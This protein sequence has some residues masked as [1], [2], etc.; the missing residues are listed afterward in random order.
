MTVLVV[1]DPAQGPD[2]EEI[3]VHC[4]ARLGSV[5]APKHVFFRD[6][7]PRTAVGKFDKKAM[8]AEFWGDSERA[9]N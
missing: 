1:A 6:A 7:L 2:A 5:K 9:V 8:R 4:K 3:I